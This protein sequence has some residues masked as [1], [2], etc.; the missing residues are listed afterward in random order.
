MIICIY[1][2]DIIFEIYK[3]EH[4]TI[5]EIM[6]LIKPIRNTRMLIPFEQFYI[7]KHYQQNKLIIE[8]HPGEQNPLTWL[9][10]ETTA[11][12]HEQPA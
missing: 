4:G 12:P 6:E 10:I 8:Q 3:H 11:A 2:E 1:S 5:D 9:A 7:Q